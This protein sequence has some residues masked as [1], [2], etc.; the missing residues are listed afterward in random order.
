V[1]NESFAIVER[2][3]EALNSGDIDTLVGLCDQDFRLDMSDR[4]FN[5]A[6]YRGHDG[7]RQF[8]AEVRDVWD[9]YVW[10]PEQLVEA[11]SD[12]VA[13][14]RTSGRGRESGAE[15]ERDTAMVWSVRGGRLMAL[16][17]YRNREEA[18]KHRGSRA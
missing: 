11:G 14:L 16:R 4:I 6:V 15:V 2:A 3:H 8:Y 5:P 7:I 9:V 1:A 17:F 12:V 13:L 10:V 18:L